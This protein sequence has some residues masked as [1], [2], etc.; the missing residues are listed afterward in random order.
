V[1]G[2][3]AGRTIDEDGVLDPGVYRLRIDA[4][5]TDEPGGTAEATAYYSVNFQLTTADGEGRGN[6]PA[7]VPLPPAVMAGG[8]MLG[9]LAA[10]RLARHRQA[11]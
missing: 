11:A 9:L 3:P 8:G 4:T 10:R 5:A 2:P 6:P 1:A 7:A